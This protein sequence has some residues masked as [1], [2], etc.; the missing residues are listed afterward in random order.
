MRESK[1]NLDVQLLQAKWRFSHARLESLPDEPMQNAVRVGIKPHH[2]SV[3][4]DAAGIG[5]Q[6]RGRKGKLRRIWVIETDEGPV[7]PAQVS[8][9]HQIRVSVNSHHRAAI[10]DCLRKRAVC[11]GLWRI[12]DRVRSIG[13]AHQAVGRIDSVHDTDA[14]SAHDCAAR[15]HV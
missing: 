13:G 7:D 9:A 6:V 10:V 14:D 3:Q 12:E 15:V 8:V 4:G 1:D 2:R 11:P 5:A